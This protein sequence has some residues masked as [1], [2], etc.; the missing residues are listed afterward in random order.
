MATHIR[1]CDWTDDTA[2]RERRGHQPGSSTFPRRQNVD[3]PGNAPTRSGSIPHLRGVAFEGRP[4]CSL[5]MDRSRFTD[6]RQARFD[7]CALD[8]SPQAYNMHMS[9]DFRLPSVE[10]LAIRYGVFVDFL[11]SRDRI[12]IREDSENVKQANYDAQP[13]RAGNGST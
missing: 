8:S 3:G 10:P 6:R 12:A 13:N 1:S 4:N 2:L 7:H 5:S 9:T 11:A